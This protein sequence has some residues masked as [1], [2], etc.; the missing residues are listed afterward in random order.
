MLT[1]SFSLVTVITGFVI[2]LLLARFLELARRVDQLEDIV[3]NEDRA[4][5]HDAMYEDAT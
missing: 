5:R 4:A 3:C 2:A 1:F